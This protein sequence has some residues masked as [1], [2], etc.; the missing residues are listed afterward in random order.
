MR[1]SHFS[2]DYKQNCLKKLLKMSEPHAG[3]ISSSVR[4][5]GDRKR[6]FMYVAYKITNCKKE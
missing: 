1:W 6:S 5:T 4:R 3:S 2:K